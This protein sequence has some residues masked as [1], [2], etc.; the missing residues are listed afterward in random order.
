M[1]FRKGSISL[2]AFRLGLTGICRVAGYHETISLLSL[3]IPPYGEQVCR[4]IFDY[5]AA[6]RELEMRNTIGTTAISVMIFLAIKK[7]QAMTRK[8]FM[9]LR[10]H[11]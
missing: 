1:S 10:F 11:T 7:P 3:R 9:A 5:R 8:K 2:T 4:N 6:S